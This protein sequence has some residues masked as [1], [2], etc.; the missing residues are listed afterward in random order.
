MN[1]GNSFYGCNF[2]HPTFLALKSYRSLKLLCAFPD[3]VSSKRAYDRGTHRTRTVGSLGWRTKNTRAVALVV[4]PKEVTVKCETVG[5]PYLK[6]H[7]DHE[8][9]G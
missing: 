4:L 2:F 8:F 9:L 6:N 7:G 3:T 5:S 1:C